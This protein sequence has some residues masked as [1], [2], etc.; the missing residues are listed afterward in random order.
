G[1]QSRTRSADELKSDP[2]ANEV[3]AGAEKSAAKVIADEAEPDPEKVHLTARVPVD[4]P[5]D[6]VK[7][8]ARKGY[9]LMFIGLEE[10]VEEDGGFTPELTRLSAGFDG[11]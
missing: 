9:D 1:A 11:P 2:V 6:V 3:K 7:D 8:E 5:S 4:D 10:A